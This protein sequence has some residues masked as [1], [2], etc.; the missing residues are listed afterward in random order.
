VKKPIAK[1]PIGGVIVIL[2][3]VVW[4]VWMAFPH[5]DGTAGGQPVTQA[6]DVTA[7]KAQS[8]AD[9]QRTA[10]DRRIPMSAYWDRTHADYSIAKSALAMALVALEDGRGVEASQLADKAKQYAFAGANDVA[11]D[12]PEGW[13]EVESH[14]SNALAGM[15]DLAGKFNDA[16]ESDH[17]IAAKKA[18]VEADE[19]QTAEMADADRIGRELFSG[20]GGNLHDL[21]RGA[22]S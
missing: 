17:P 16:V 5:P 22:E 11:K 2:F 6:A 7:S 21:S 14:L 13:G 20:A 4:G 1:P 9:K 12:V 18:M 8:L 3:F 19:Y 15:A 10:H